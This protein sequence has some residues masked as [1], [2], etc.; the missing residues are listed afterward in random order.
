MTR[1]S[2]NVSGIASMSA[3]RAP[4]RSAINFALASFIGRI[5]YLASSGFPNSCIN[6]GVINPKTALN[7]KLQSESTSCWRFS[8][9]FF[10]RGLSFNCSFAIS[11]R[12]ETNIDDS[13]VK[14]N[15]V[16]IEF[17]SLS[18]PET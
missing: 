3:T 7:G 12:S 10:K 15:Q 14:G 17:P 1:S 18:R 11:Q 8:G 9:R 13:T 6:P 2:S 4:N 5:P 16:V